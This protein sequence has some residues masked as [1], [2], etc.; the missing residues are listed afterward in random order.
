MLL[1]ITLLAAPAS[2]QEFVSTAGTIEIEQV[3]PVTEIDFDEYALFGE[4]VGPDTKMVTD[5]PRPVFNPLIR[6]RTSFG[7]EMVRSL[8]TMK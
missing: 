6:L 4:F 2:A 5:R 1:V 8:D 7:G 3:A